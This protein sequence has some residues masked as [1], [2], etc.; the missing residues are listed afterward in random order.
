VHGLEVVPDQQHP[1]LGQHLLHQSTPLR[2]LLLIELRAE[3][4]AADL[5]DDAV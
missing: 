5:V 2:R 1:V 3:D 4:A